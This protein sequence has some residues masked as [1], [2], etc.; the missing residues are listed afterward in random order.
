[1]RLRSLRSLSPLVVAI[2]LVATASTGVALYLTTR[3]T[4]DRLVDQRIDAVARTVIGDPPA[5]TRAVLLHRIAHRARDRDTGDI[6]FFLIGF[7]SIILIL[8]GGLTFFGI[9]VSRRVGEM[10]RTIDAVID[11]D[12]RRRVPVDASGGAFARQAR[13]FNRMLDRIAD[14]MTGIGNVSSDIAHDLRAPLARLHGQLS[15][16]AKHPDAATLRPELEAAIAQGDHLLA[17]FAAVL[18]IAEVEGG[19]RRARFA[20]LDLGT[21]AGEIARMMIPVA[22]E[23]G[24]RLHAGAMVVA[25]IMGDRQLLTQML[26]NVIENAMRHTPSGTTITI[27]VAGRGDQ[28]IL[29]IADDGPG[30]APDRRALA[31]RRFGRLDASQ[32]VAG[33]GLGLPLV[34]AIARLHRG[35]VALEDA[36]PGLRVAIA[37]PLA[38]R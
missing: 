6:H 28:A 15:R 18:R 12:M 22:E 14:R 20:P 25:P 10:R 34:Q 23:S 37:I 7:G 29:A 35:D 33:H 26:M 30:I 1:M 17:M 9:T 24:H 31:M 19:D 5:T 4:I 32:P 38:T 2:M 16:L 36:A 11:G 3:A 13:A 8:I 27:D 21:L